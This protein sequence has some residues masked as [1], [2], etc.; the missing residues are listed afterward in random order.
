MS[1]KERE[2]L[3]KR[4]EILMAALRLFAEKGFENTTMDEIAES[5]EFGK[6]T[7]YNYFENK[8]DIYKGILDKTTDEQLESLRLIAESTENFGDFIQ[9][10]T[11]QIFS[12]YVTNRSEL[13]FFAKLK[14]LDYN[15]F[16]NCR[17]IWGE[18]NKEIEKIYMEKIEKGIKT[19]ELKNYEPVSILNFFRNSIFPYLFHLI[20][21][22]DAGEF[23]SEK[24]SK[25]FL[26]VIFY[27]ILKT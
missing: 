14:I 4:N 9:N 24:E 3:Q 11:K 5:A 17:E 12:K 20:I 13:L 27:G 8:S 1:R 25:F 10:L 19:G 22:K 7:I 2:K 18:K 23:D 16:N 21:T 6:G 15:R 26:D